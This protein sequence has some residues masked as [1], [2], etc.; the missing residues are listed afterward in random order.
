MNTPSED[1]PTIEEDEFNEFFDS[2]FAFSETLNNDKFIIIDLLIAFLESN[3][4]LQQ[5]F[6]N[7]I[8]RTQR[9]Y[10]FISDKFDEKID[11]FIET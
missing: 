10:V 5:A 1:F 9:I 6:L 7:R 2:D 8:N 4:L 3:R 11:D